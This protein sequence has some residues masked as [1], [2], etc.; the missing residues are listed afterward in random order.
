MGRERS[1]RAGVGAG[2]AGAPAGVLAGVL[3]GVKVVVKVG[4]LAGVKVVVLAGVLAG[5]S[6]SPPVVIERAGPTVTAAGPGSDP[7]SGPGSAAGPGSVPGSGP[8]SEAG[9]TG[10]AGW[11]GPGAVEANAV[12]DRVVDGDTVRIRLGADGSG[13]EE[14]VRLIGIDTP[15]TKRPDTPV[16]CFGPEAS[17]ALNDALP[18]GTRLRL[19]L[20]V[21]ERDRYGRLLAYVYRADDGLFLNLALARG[22]FAVLLTYP[23]NVAH[24][25]EFVA[26]V[27]AARD[28]GLGLWSACV[29][30]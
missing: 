11:V 6:S 14:P 29:A 3:A 12:V 7:G 17:Q 24:T 28:E 10:P 20:D 25:D 30:R 9:R 1:Q 5:C 18:E 4:V 2:S 8:G 13:A 27:A 19:E 21:E 22:G 23:P 15:E 16:Q 26:A